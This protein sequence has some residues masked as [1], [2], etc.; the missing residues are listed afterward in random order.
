LTKYTKYFRFSIGDF[1]LILVVK[2]LRR[3]SHAALTPPKN[4]RKADDFLNLYEVVH[5]SNGGMSIISTSI[6][7]SLAIIERGTPWPIIASSV[8]PM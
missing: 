3:L 6:G 1:G 5:S 8:T 4:L 7:R 2:A